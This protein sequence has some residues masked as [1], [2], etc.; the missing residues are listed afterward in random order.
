[1]LGQP[2]VWLFF[3]AGFGCT[4]RLPRIIGRG[5]ASL[6]LFTGGAFTAEEALAMGL[7]D[8]VVPHEQLGDEC[9]KFAE[10]ISKQDLFA[11]RQTKACI[12]N[13]LEAGLSAGLSYESQAFGLCFSEPGQ[14]SLMQAFMEKSAKKSS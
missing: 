12:R 2:E 14:Q 4:Q 13:G 6:M 1:M 9:T 10:K 5:R 8:K 11:V 3:T 7:I